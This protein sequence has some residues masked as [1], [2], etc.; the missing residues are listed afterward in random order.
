MKYVTYSVVFDFMPDAACSLLGVF[1][2]MPEVACTYSG[3]FNVMPEV[4]CNL[5][6]VRHYVRSS[7]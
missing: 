7:M 3:V 1:N 5:V 6:L 4:A 2:V